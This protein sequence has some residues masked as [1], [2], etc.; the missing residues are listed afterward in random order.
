MAKTAK[1]SRLLQYN[2]MVD[3]RF[4]TTICRQL[5]RGGRDPK[6][7]LEKN[8]SM[9]T[10]KL[11]PRLSKTDS[12]WHSLLLTLIAS[13]LSFQPPQ[14]AKFSLVCF[15]D[16]V[17][18]TSLSLASSACVV[19]LSDCISSRRHQVAASPAEVSHSNCTARNTSKYHLGNDNKEKPNQR[20]SFV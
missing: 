10:E 20:L 12:K 15:N 1:A 6:R 18:H 3:E 4:V 2:A 9:D 14:Q 5:W 7:V 8:M 13:L 11:P 16:I 17:F 19:C